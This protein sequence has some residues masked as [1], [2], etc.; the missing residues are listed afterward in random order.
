MKSTWIMQAPFHDSR[1]C[2]YTLIFIFTPISY[3]KVG[4]DSKAGWRPQYLTWGVCEHGLGGVAKIRLIVKHQVQPGRRW[5]GLRSESEGHGRLCRILTSVPA[6]QTQPHTLW[7]SAVS[8]GGW[9]ARCVCWAH[10]SRLPA[11]NAFLPILGRCLPTWPY[12]LETP[13]K[14]ISN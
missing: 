10:S 9:T 7:S 14:L 6:A 2:H 11:T 5:A 3:T 8:R 12:P 1:C 4:Q 13:F